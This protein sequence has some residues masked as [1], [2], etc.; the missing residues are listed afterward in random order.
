[1]RSGAL[2]FR[3]D[4]LRRTEVTDDVGGATVTWVPVMT[5]R[6]A[7]DDIG[8]REIFR[9]A[10]LAAEY[11]RRYVIRDPE[12]DIDATMRLRDPAGNGGEEFEIRRF[13]RLP[14]LQQGIEIFV[15]AVDRTGRIAA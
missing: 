3:I 4:F 10:G 12:N 5:V 15:T 9:G 8:G 11:D 2:Y 6:A 7:R 14:G 1:M 13:A